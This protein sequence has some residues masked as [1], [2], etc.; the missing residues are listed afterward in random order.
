[1]VLSQLCL[2]GSAQDRKPLYVRHV[3]LAPNALIGD[4][5]CLVSS[6]AVGERGACLSAAP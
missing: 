3:I 1:M 5:L 2:F 4:S 6:E